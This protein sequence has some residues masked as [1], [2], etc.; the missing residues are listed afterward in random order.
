MGAVAAA[1]GAGAA[2]DPSV[3]FQTII[4]LYRQTILVVDKKVNGDG[5]EGDKAKHLVLK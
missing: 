4:L 2:N 5:A 3:I 1:G